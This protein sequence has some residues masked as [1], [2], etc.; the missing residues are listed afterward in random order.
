[1][2]FTAQKSCERFFL[3]YCILE[4]NEPNREIATKIL[5][6][7]GIIVD[8]AEDGDIAVEKMQNAF[9]RCKKH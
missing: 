7:E 1:M 9:C 4:D 3:P 5:E 6:E 2:P 8:T